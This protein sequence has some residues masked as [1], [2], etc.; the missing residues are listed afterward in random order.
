MDN[1]NIMI[2][3]QNIGFSYPQRPVLKNINFKLYKGQ[4][5]GLIGPNGSGKSTFLHLIMGLVK[6]DSGTLW[7]FN[8]AVASEKAFQEARKRIGLV[9]QNA[10]DQLF[11]PTVLED[12][13]FGPLNQGKTPEQARDKSL[14]LLETLDLKGFENRITYKLSGGEKRLVAL[15]TVLVM[16]PEILLLDEPFT[17]LDKS[18]LERILD[19]LNHLNIS[20]IIVSHEFDSLA[21]TTTDI[22]TMDKGVIVYN[23]KSDILH[24][25]FH[26][27]PGGKALHHHH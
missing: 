24:S 18:T 17:G 16:E 6:P 25:H 26:K 22:C 27:H 15:A 8:Q 13:C 11:S 5:M 12:I 19:I 7:L 1:Q 4:K 2:Q 3:M 14:H 21:K 9:F 10:D 20:Y 23:G